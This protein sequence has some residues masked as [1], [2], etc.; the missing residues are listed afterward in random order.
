ML[1]DTLTFVGVMDGSGV[2]WDV[3]C[4]VGDFQMS[5]K[6]NRVLMVIDRM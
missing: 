2:G 4:I 5:N 3:G 6:L 1:N